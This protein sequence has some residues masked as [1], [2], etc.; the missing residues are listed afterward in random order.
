MEVLYVVEEINDSK[1][2]KGIK[3]KIVTCGVCLQSTSDWEQHLQREHKYLAWK[4]N[5]TKVVSMN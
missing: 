1:N 5:E 2:K 3:D 4:S